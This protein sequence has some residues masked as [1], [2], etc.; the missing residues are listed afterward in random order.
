MT[1]IKGT[2]V[3][4]ITPFQSDT[5][6]DLQ[7]LRTLVQ[8][9]IQGGVDF[10]V[11]LGTTGESVTL[12]EAEA[13]SVL[14][15]VFEQNQGRL[16]VVMGCGGND[17]HKVIR[18][19]RSYDALYRADA[20]LSVT[21]YYNKPSQDGL[22]KHFADIA[23][24]T[25]KSIILYNVPGRTG[26]NMLPDTVI[27][28]ANDFDNI[29]ALKEASGNIEQG[30]EILR[31]KPDAFTLL[32]GDDTLVV[33][34]IACGYEGVISVAANGRPGDFSQMVNRALSGDLSEA[35]RLYY[36][37][38]PWMQLL[39]KEGNPTG[40]KTWMALHD[41]VKDTVRNPLMPGTDMLRNAF[42]DLDNESFA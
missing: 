35:N 24:S 27:R 39:F 18:K 8:N 32:S 15:T 41:M 5:S 6:L 26:V 12:T 14:Q 19:L 37:L 36:R 2:G 9:M 17:T 1:K 29:I 40:I 34:Q 21:P 20:Y 25:D 23:S 16:P 30:V 11:P 22:Y 42:R 10:L 3:A 7:A 38:F 4:L 13:D 33:P 28:L 31:R